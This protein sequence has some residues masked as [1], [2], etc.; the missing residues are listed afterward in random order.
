MKEK[1][2]ED[3]HCGRK[4]EYMSE[5]GISILFSHSGGKLTPATNAAI[6]KS[7]IKNSAIDA[8]STL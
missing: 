8:I 2:L 3:L 4:S 1:M 5:V 7:K 6:I